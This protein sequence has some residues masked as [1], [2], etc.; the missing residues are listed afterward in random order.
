MS[1]RL[2][3]G[4]VPRGLNVK[5]KK[6]WSRTMTTIEPHALWVSVQR[7]PHSSV[8]GLTGHNRPETLKPDS[9]RPGRSFAVARD[10]IPINSEMRP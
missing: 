10:H 9:M 1:W 5:A 2:V 3:Q 7:R 8:R 6:S 4:P